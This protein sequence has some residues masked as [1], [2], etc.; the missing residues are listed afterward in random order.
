MSTDLANK[1]LD[2]MF[3][4]QAFSSTADSVYLALSTTEL[5]DDDADGG[6]FTEC[7]G[8]GYS[9]ELVMSNGSS[10]TPTWDLAASGVVDNG[11][12]IVFGPPSAADWGTIVAIVILDGD[13]LGNIL[14]YDNDNVVDQ[15]PGSGDTVQIAAGACDITVT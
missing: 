4:N 8:T 6:D 5:D 11:E 2:V 1:L 14:F 13:S 9:R 12:A 10:L 15:E 7:A 3:R